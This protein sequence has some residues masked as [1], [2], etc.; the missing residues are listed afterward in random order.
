MLTTSEEPECRR[1]VLDYA[2]RFYRVTPEYLCRGS[3]FGFAWIPAK[4]MRE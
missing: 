1:V 4:G 3:R 2:R